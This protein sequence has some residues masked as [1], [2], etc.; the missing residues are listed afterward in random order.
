MTYS[1]R[2][3]ILIFF[4]N[5]LVSLASAAETNINSSDN[6]SPIEQS[7]NFQTYISSNKST[8]DELQKL[9]KDRPLDMLN[10]VRFNSKAQY[11]QSN[12]F[13]DR[14]WSGR[15]AYDEYTRHSSPIASR[16]GASVTYIG[17]PELILIGPEHEQWDAVFIVSYPNLAS[18]LALVNDPEYKKHAFHRAAA[19]A[20]SRLI[21]M[22][23]HSVINE[24]HKKID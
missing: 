7:V 2:I 11:E 15:Q 20:D 23:S 17:G 9:P 8:Y 6:T 21:R 22:D 13:F 5:W 10:M 19:I 14:G 1:A 18:F 3:S 24:F 12:P 16:E 4:M